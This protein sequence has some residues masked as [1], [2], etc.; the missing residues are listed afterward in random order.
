M[1]MFPIFMIGLVVGIAVSYAFYKFKQDIPS[2]IKL[3]TQENII[4]QQSNDNNMLESLN[5]K[6]YDKIDRLEHELA[7]YKEAE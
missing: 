1:A 5:K 2:D 4:K 7:K 3:R 6:L